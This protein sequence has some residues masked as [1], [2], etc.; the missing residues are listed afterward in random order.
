MSPLDDPSARAAFEAPKEN[1][2]RMSFGDHL[3]ELRKRVFRSLIA[4]VGAVF[5]MMPFHDNVM[6][7]IVEPYRILWKD[8]F[9]EYVVDLEHSVNA[10]TKGELTPEWTGREKD[11]LGYCKANEPA[12]LDG[13]FPQKYTY[14][15]PQLTGFQV[16]YQLMAVGGVEDLWTFMLAAFLFALSLS[17]P[18]VVWQ[19]WAFIAAGLYQK[20]RG[21]STATSRS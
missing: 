13:S 8:A 5:L 9:R 7:L 12:I 3:D 6:R 16:P 15:L 19:V 20:E 1:L 4:I 21:S 17:S 18:I 10:P 14:M 11:W 2:Q